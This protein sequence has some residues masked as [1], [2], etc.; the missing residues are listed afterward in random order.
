DRSRDSLC[1]DVLEAIVGAIHIDQGGEVAGT[2]VARTILSMID[3]LSKQSLETNPKGHLQK[4]ILQRSGHLP[5]YRVLDQSGRNNDRIFLV[6]VFEKE[7]LL[8]TGQASS[9]KEA[10]RLAA[11][12]ALEQIY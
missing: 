10:G 2:F 1:A 3:E 6:G 8:G 7:A 12:E 5:R 11:R 4:L 9:I